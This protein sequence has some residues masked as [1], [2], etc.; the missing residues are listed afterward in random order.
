MFIINLKKVVKE[1]PN[2]HYKKTHSPSN[3]AVQAGDY[4]IICLNKMLFSNS[5]NGKEID[6]DLGR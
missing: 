4:F 1:L 3:L 5:K 2:F 6:N